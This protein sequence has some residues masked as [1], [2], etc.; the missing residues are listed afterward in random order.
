MRHKAASGY[1]V[2]TQA[3]IGYDI[4]NR[5]TGQKLLKFDLFNNF[6][7]PG[8]EKELELIMDRMHPSFEFKENENFKQ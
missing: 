3:L 6:R 8:R 7:K 1:C 5:K 2:F 4:F